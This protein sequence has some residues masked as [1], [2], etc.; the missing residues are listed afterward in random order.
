MKDANYELSYIR[1]S[2]E[3]LEAYLL[4]KELFWPVVTPPHQ[5]PFQKLTLGNLLLS[6]NKLNGYSEGRQLSTTQ[7]SVYAQL[8]RDIEEFRQKWTVAWE[9]KATHEYKSRL[10]QWTHYLNDLNKNEEPHAPYYTSEVRIR[11]LLELLSEYAS[12]DFQPGLAP[13][14]V[15]FRARL[16]PAEFIWDTDF[17]S[18]FPHEQFWFLYGVV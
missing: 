16:H 11:V 8:K 7:R 9:T 12:E 1:A 2:L 4:S 17:Q 5:R 14:D 18:A 13:L 10:R 6:L 15:F 3:E